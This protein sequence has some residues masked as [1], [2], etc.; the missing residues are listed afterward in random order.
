VL[1][2]VEAGKGGKLTTSPLIRTVREEI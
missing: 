1:R 2:A